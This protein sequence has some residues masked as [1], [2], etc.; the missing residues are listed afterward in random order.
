[1]KVPLSQMGV[2]QTGYYTEE[3][4]TQEVPTGFDFASLGELGLLP[5]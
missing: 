4:R 5:A 2:C 1:M 3:F